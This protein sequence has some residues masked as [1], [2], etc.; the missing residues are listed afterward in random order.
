MRDIKKAL[1]IKMHMDPKEK[2]PEDYHEWLDV[3]DHTAIE[4][5]PHIGMAKIMQLS[6]SQKQMGLPRKSHGDLFTPCHK[7]SSWCY[8]TLSMNYWTRGSFML[9]NLLRLPQC[10]SYESQGAVYGFV[11]ITAD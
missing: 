5:L 8:A 9:A 2:L 7:T 6:L 10:S 4:Q 3:F 11:W 1:K